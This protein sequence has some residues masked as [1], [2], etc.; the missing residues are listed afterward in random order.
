MATCWPCGG[1]LIWGGDHD[2]DEEEDDSPF[3]MV[4]NLSCPNCGVYVEV[5][6]PKEGEDAE[7][8]D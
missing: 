7:G 5:Y 6:Y 4:S 2:F 1:E 3:F 8:D